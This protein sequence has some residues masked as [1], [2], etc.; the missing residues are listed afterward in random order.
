MMA[1]DERDQ[2][3]SK[4]QTRFRPK[5]NVH[6]TEFRMNQLRIRSVEKKGMK[7]NEDKNNKTIIDFVHTESLVSPENHFQHAPEPTTFL[8]YSI[9]NINECDGG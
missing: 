7:R 4:Q 2:R 5:T 6:T 3:L 8:F 1:R 9:Y